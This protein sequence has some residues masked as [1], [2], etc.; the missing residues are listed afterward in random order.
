MLYSF[1]VIFNNFLRDSSIEGAYH[2]RSLSPEIFQPMAGTFGGMYSSTM[3]NQGQNTGGFKGQVN[4]P[5]SSKPASTNDSSSP[6]AGMSKHQLYDIMSQMKVLIEQNEQQARQILIDNP[7][8]TKALFQAQ[9]ML[10]MVRPPKV[11]PNLQQPLTHLP[12]KSLS[13]GQQTQSQPRQPSASLAVSAQSLA[14]NRFPAQKQSGQHAMK[15]IAT[16]SQPLNASVESSLQHSQSLSQPLQVIQQTSQVPNVPLQIPLPQQLPSQF[17]QQTSQSHSLPM[18]QTPA[19]TPPQ[20]VPLQ[21]AP[22]IFSGHSQQPLTQQP[23]GRPQTV[24]PPLPQQPR[25]PLQQL[26]Q[27]MQNQ[28]VQS[29]GFQPS[30]VSQQ[31][32]SQAK[33]MPH[34]QPPLPTQPPPQQ[35]FQVNTGPGGSIAPSS[36]SA[37][38]T[39]ARGVGQSNMGITGHGMPSGR[40]PNMGQGV[41]G[42]SPVVPWPQTPTEGGANLVSGIATSAGPNLARSQAPHEMQNRASQSMPVQQQQQMQI[43]EQE[44]MLLEQVV[45]LTVEQINTLPPEVRPQIF[46][47]QKRFRGATSN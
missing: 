28:T 27:Q 35:M 37:S 17:M 9:I 29:M 44:K 40:G 47:L 46:E 26:P 8:M 4:A 31:H 14:P 2:I 38:D 18:H 25:P 30:F 19:S 21:S 22:N 34:G 5:A 33:F 24:L 23:T 11:M 12:Q 43:P 45:N 41:G 15:P 36:H 39:S 42:T 7:A 3:D 13:T 32:Q 6:L 1:T 16:Q 20:N 10:G